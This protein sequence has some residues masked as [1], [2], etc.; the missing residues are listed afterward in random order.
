MRS[1]KQFVGT[2]ASPLVIAMLL[3]IC[4]WLFRRMT[5][6]RA[7]RISLVGSVL[8]AWLGSTPLVGALLL[9]PLESQY[10][11]PSRAEYAGVRLVVVLGSYYAPVEGLPVSS[12][13][14][15]EGIRRAV[16]G[17]RLQRLLPDSILVV[18]GG[19]PNPEEAPA[20]GAARL[21]RELGVD[22]QSIR[23]LPDAL[24]TREEAR[25]IARLIG[26]QPFLLIT[27]AAHMPRAMTWMQR[28]G[29]R[30]IA[31][32]T[33]FRTANMR[34]RWNSCLPSAGGLRMTELAVHE[35]LGLLAQRLG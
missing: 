14:D 22:P 20:I 16:E 4:A 26:D 27:S 7:A 3:M 35:Y 5:W 28:A 6:L 34:L 8:V 29:M 13:L 32:A 17:I 31:A 24:D 12:L 15:D 18:S 2:I 21:A 25:E 23:L 30:P 11:P 9:A 1:L 19:A 10:P 33:S